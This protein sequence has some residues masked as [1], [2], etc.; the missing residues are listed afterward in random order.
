MPQD[1]YFAIGFGKSML[2]IDMILWQANGNN[3]AVSDLWSTGH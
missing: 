1:N 3:S 2:N